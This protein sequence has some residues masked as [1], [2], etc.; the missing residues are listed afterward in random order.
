[1]KTNLK[2][3]VDTGIMV[4]LMA[5]AFIAVGIIPAMAGTGASADVWQERPL[6]RHKHHPPALGIW[7][8]PQL[9]EELELT[10]EQISQ[11]RDADFTTLE[12]RLKLKGQ[13]D[14]YRLQL[15]KAFSDDSVDG[16]A[17]HQLAEKIAGIKGDL[18]VQDVVSRLTLGEILS[19]NQLDKLKL[20]MMP[21]AEKGPCQGQE[22]LAAVHSSS[23]PGGGL[24]LP[25]EFNE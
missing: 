11:L 20:H 13:L 14:G 17:V 4:L 2:K 7:R 15:D 21:K 8:N 19:A 25:P 24:P 12:K 3:K 16:K 5:T 18:F 1:M 10:R 22:P 23:M 6:G 9:V